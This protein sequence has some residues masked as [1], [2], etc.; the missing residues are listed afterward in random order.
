MS[1]RLKALQRIR[2]SRRWLSVI[3]KPTSQLQKL[4]TESRISIG[5]CCI[6]TRI[7]SVVIAKIGKLCRFGVS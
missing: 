6:V 3:G 7:V 1:D 4:K 5:S 2:K